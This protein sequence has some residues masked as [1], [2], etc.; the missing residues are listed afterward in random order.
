MALRLARFDPLNF[1]RV[2]ASHAISRHAFSRDRLR[3]E[4][5]KVA[6]HLVDRRVCCAK[7]SAHNG[8]ARIGFAFEFRFESSDSARVEVRNARAGFADF[9][10]EF[11]QLLADLC[12]HL[13]GVTHADIAIAIISR[14]LF[15]GLLHRAL[16]LG[17][18]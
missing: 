6:R 16:E 7:E 15:R 12:A 10:S 1:E 3:E 14:D 13:N 2:D 5:R 11:L 8:V 4:R 18:E 17:S 9:H